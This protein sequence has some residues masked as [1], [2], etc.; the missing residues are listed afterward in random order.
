MQRSIVLLGII[1]FSFNA[2]G[3]GLFQGKRNKHND[4]NPATT[5]KPVKIK[6]YMGLSGGI[7]NSAGMLGFEYERCLAPQYSISGGVGASTWGVKFYVEGRYY[8]RASRLG[9]AFG[10]GFTMASGVNNL[11]MSGGKTQGNTFS[12][13]KLYPQYNFFPSATY[14]WRIG[15]HSS[16][17]FL[18]L[19][20]S[21][22]V[23]DVHYLVTFGDPL[24]ESRKQTLNMLAPSGLMIGLGCCFANRH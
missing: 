2:S 17:G 11:A 9:W 15:R 14:F 16:R 6:R 12:E 1:L 19:G 7:N 22:R 5:E 13:V 8:R 24:T 3:Q 21:V 18:R 23:S 20:Y 4:N 10:A